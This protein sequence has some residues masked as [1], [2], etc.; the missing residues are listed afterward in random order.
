MNRGLFQALDVADQ[1]RF[2]VSHVRDG[3]T[4]GH[5]DDR[6][7]DVLRETGDLRH[8]HVPR[9]GEITFELVGS[10]ALDLADGCFTLRRD[11]RELSDDLLGRR[12]SIDCAQVVTAQSTDEVGDGRLD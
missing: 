12:Q 1:A 8:T 2:E 3:V 4:G 6:P 10:V 5:D 11:V 9:I 7:N